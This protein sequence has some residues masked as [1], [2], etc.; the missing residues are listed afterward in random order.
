MSSEYFNKLNYTMSNEDTEFEYSILPENSNHVLCIAGSGSRVVP[1][2]AKKPKR[3]SISDYSKEQL[4]LTAT[5]IACLKILTHEE[6]I[7]FWGYTYLDRSQRKIIFQ[8]LE[9]ESEYKEIM[10]QIFEAHNWEPLLYVGKYEKMLQSFSC[11]IQKV[12][13]SHIKKLSSFKEHKNFIEYLYT[14]FPRF[15]WKILVSLLGNS[16]LFNALLYKGNHP[17]KNIKGSYPAYY[18]RMFDQL[19]QFL[20]PRESFFLQMIFFGKIQYLEGAPF[21]ASSQI[22]NDMKEGALS[23][24]IDYYQGDLFSN[25]ERINSK[26]D[27]V[28]FSDILSYFQGNLEKEYL[29]L[30]KEKLNTKALTIHRY[31][32]R[33][34]KDIDVNGFNKITEKFRTK[35]DREKTQIYL[36]DVYERKND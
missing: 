9:I 8:R 11:I 33:I 23:C 32:L 10:K 24:H 17:K 30:I 13:G 1:L 15:R 19:F 28:S 5:R 31:Y 34:N 26:I 3:L 18:R 21:E 25:L 12:L 35:I 29:Q 4:A 6:Y 27:F 16:T 7:K 22:Y 14:T 2:L 20:V 36:I